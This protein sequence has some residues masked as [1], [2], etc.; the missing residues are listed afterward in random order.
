MSIIEQS[1]KRNHISTNDIDE[2]TLPIVFN[3]ALNCDKDSKFKILRY[4]EII[5]NIEDKKSQNYIFG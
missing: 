1:I 4:L 2:T 5:H 3:S